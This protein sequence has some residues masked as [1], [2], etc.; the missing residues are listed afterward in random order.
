MSAGREFHV[1]G[2]ATDLHAYIHTYLLI[3]M[4]AYLLTCLHTYILTYLLTYLLIYVL[5]YFTHTKQDVNRP[6]TESHV[7]GSNSNF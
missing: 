1:C 6:Y 7:I 3:C 4:L 2:A 5:T